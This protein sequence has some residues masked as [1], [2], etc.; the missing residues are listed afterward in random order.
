MSNNITVLLVLTADDLVK[1]YGSKDQFVATLV[2]GQGKAYANQ[3]IEFNINGIFYIR[4]TDSVGQAKLNI[5][6]P[7]GEYIITSKY[8]NGATVSNK[9]T[10]KN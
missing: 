5:N 6:L 9:I 1:K 3:K 7:V 10:V 4:T 2:D 8:E